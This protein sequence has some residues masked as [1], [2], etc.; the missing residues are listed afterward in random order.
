MRENADFRVDRGPGRSRVQ[1]CRKSEDRLPVPA[2]AKW[3]VRV[4]LN[5]VQQDIADIQ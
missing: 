1:E 5:K 2:N 4:L 3:K